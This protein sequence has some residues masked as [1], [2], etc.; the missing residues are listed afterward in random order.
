MVHKVEHI[1]APFAIEL[2]KAQR[3]CNIVRTAITS[4]GNP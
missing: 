3:A 1:L 4:S 2:S